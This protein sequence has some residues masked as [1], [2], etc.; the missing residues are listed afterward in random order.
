MDQKKLQETVLM[1]QLLEKQREQFNE[2]L[3]LLERKRMELE[4]SKEATKTISDLKEEKE[5]LVPLGGDLFSYGKI[6][7]T[8]NILVNIGAG[9]MIKNDVKSATE[10]IDTR[11][12]EIEN[13][14][15][16]L[17]QDMG[18]IENKMQDLAHQINSV[19]QK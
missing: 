15:N 2:Q 11:L 7:D 18:K 13:I 16:K 14:K 10:F 1:Y 17:I 5:T 19:Q 6:S 12:K 4:I 9:I 3:G 8:K